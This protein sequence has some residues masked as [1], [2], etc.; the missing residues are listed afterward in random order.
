MSIDT[1]AALAAE[2][3]RRIVAGELRAGMRLDP[4]RQAAG[5]LGLA[6]NTVA[7]AYR[8]LAERGLVSGRGR[9]GTFV[10]D[11]PRPGGDLA[12]HVPDG[13]VDLSSGV[14]DPGLLPDLGPV[15]SSL[16]GSDTTYGDP[17]V[18]PELEGA[19]RS[20]LE[21]VRYDQI[22]VT[23][24]AVDGIER[25][26]AAHLRPGDAVAV[27][28]PGWFVTSD[29]VRAMGL[30]P[31]PVELDDDGVIPDRLERV[32]ARVSAL[33]VTPRAQNPTGA[34]TGPARAAELAAMLADRP[35]LL[36]VEDDH[37]GP[38]G[39]GTLTSLTG[40]T[41]RS[42]HIRSF[43]KALGPDLRTAVV[44]GDAV[45][46]D[47]LL[48]RQLLGTGWVSHVLQRTTARLLRAPAV[49]ELARRATSVYRE[50]REALLAA[51]AD[52][53]LDARGRSGL[54]VWVEVDDE[55]RV[56]RSALEAGFAV[57]SGRRF[58]LG[59]AP[60]V[61][62]TAARLDPARASDVAAALA[63]RPGLRRS[64]PV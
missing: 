15:L 12:P 43:S 19:V 63:G 50:R 58:R 13:V 56:E 3:E 27:E 11:R 48:E 45:T 9:A 17:S 26:L 25:A 62:V 28:D 64:R 14:P 60:G 40:A 1:A 21:G 34:V 24:G 2:L 35:G 8:T 57:R 6:P 51:L 53:G 18:A 55:E 32:L 36:V 47:R 52:E 42:V 29:L 16:E 44:A 41:D 30:V 38:V 37:M 4:V 7:A 46:M 20:L 22:A 39:G 54:N 5:S 31:V 33:V 59:S 23:G 10:E 61:R 49:G